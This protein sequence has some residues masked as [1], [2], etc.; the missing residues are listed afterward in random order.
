MSHQIPES[1]IKALKQIEKIVGQKA[2]EKDLLNSEIYFFNKGLF[3]QIVDGHVVA[4]RLDE[5]RRSLNYENLSLLKSFSKLNFLVLVRQ[6]I[7]EISP[8][9]N[10]NYLT[11]L[12]L[13]YNQIQDIKPIQN[14][15]NLTHLYL[16]DNQIQDIKPIQNF[17]KLTHLALGRNQI[18]NIKPI[19]N[20][21]NLTHLYLPDNQ[22]QDIKP[23][24]NFNKLTNLAL[25]RNQ[26]QNIN[27]IQ[28][29]DNLTKLDLSY[30]QIQD[31]KPIQNLDNLIRLGLSKNKIQ[32]IK[33]IQN[34]NKLTQ[35]TL[36]GNQILSIKPIQN[37][38]KLIKLDIRDNQIQDIPRIFFEVPLN[39]KPKSEYSNEGLIWEYN[40]LKSPPPEIL[41]QGREAVLA[42][43]DS[44]ENQ[45][46]RPLNEVKIILVGDGAAGKTSL[47]KALRGVP[48]NANEKQTHGINIDPW[49]IQF[50]KENINT[51]LWDFGGQEIMH[52]THTFFLTQR[53]IY[54]LVL[55]SRQDGGK[56][57]YWL[58]HINTYGGNSPVIVVL[59][60]QDENPSFDVDRKQL[61][62]KYPN[63]KAFVRFSCAQPNAYDDL[64]KVIQQA[65]FNSE[66]RQTSFAQN[67]FEV[68]DQLQAITDD[69]I[70]I[71]TYQDLCANK[72]I[73]A[74]AQKTLLD[75]LDS[76]G[77]VLRFEHDNTTL[78]FNPEWLTQAVYRIINS[79]LVA[80]QQGRFNEK[81]IGQLL[82]PEKE[83][84]YEYPK[85]K[86]PF[87]T[88]LIERFELGFKE[89]DNNWLIPALLP[90]A[91]P[92]HGFY[93]EKKQDRSIHLYLQ[94]TFLPKSIFPRLLTVFKDEVRQGLVWRHGAILK[95]RETN[96]EALISIDHAV[97]RIEICVKGY[98]PRNYLSLIRRELKHINDSFEKL[99]VEEWVP[100]PEYNTQVK[101]ST[102]INHLKNR[103]DNLYLDEVDAK[104]NVEVLLNGIEAFEDTQ[105]H[106]HTS[107]NVTFKRPEA[108]E[109]GF[110]GEVA[111][112]PNII[113]NNNVGNGNN[114]SAASNEGGTLNAQYDKGKG[115]LKA[116][117]WERV[118]RTNL[119]ISIIVGLLAIISFIL[120]YNKEDVSAKTTKQQPQEQVEK[121]QPQDSL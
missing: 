9:K 70:D 14:L 8:I 63:I 104:V 119:I 71:E 111:S 36:S 93:N 113:I 108:Q 75:F 67:W 81:D 41:V 66:L 28:N 23:I 95:N 25:R 91:E 90:I 73:K 117:L 107:G 34:L 110:G 56:P 1:E 68:K 61:Q 44:L 49:A 35:L 64:E 18:Q 20:L 94:Y 87:I 13:S 102:L 38:N 89:D 53:S 31:I 39:P 26:I 106:R 84:D 54:V 78:V 103:V 77:I 85:D 99:K 100:I 46:A 57:E 43:F 5:T 21:N 109:E 45:E 116:G 10:L 11:H 12:N 82:A 80:T 101:Y 47:S 65:V 120:L 16:L 24:Q 30:N 62:R 15:N 72:D 114:V 97:K 33:P 76:L 6:D 48:Y 121:E 32:D 79:P 58:D 83:N 55:D 86:H 112:T 42:Y 98:D 52:A 40:P 2:E 96:Q 105:R 3:Y 29:L 74:N 59:N 17:N 60:K 27:P 51:Y 50:E 92:D 19:Q 115:T 4:L 88:G 69:Y 118:N 37:L 22:I 7:Q